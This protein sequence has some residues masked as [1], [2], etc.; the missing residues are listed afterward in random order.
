[1]SSI[2]DTVIEEVKDFPCIYFMDCPKEGCM[3]DC[4]KIFKNLS[5]KLGIRYITGICQKGAFSYYKI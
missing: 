2:E 5:E 3:H 1:M 4:K